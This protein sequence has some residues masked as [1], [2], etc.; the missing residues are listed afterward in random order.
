MIQIKTHCY[1]KKTISIINVNKNI[2]PTK[3]VD[4]SFLSTF[5]KNNFVKLIFLHNSDIDFY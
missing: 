5:R 2:G 4:F 1:L 3:F